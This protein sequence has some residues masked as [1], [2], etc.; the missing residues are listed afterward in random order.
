MNKDGLAVVILHYGRPELAARIHRQLLRSDPDWSGDIFVLDNAAPE[1]YAGAWRRCST[2]LHWAGALEYC[3]G[4]FSAQGYSH[5]WFLNND[6]Y[7]FA[8]KDIIAQAWIRYKFACRKWGRVGVYSPAAHRNPY[9]PQMVC[10]PEAEFSLVRYVD[11]IAPLVDMDFWKQIGGIDFAGNPYGYGV[12][13]WCTSRAPELGWVV[14]VDHRI[15]LRHV[16]HSTSARIDGYLGTASA[17]EDEY[18]KTRMG[19]DYRDRIKAMAKD[20]QLVGANDL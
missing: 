18:L 1:A 12:D 8:H 15:V 6:I 14:V 9:H 17:A 4:E 16:Y 5:L 7:F 10:R 2:N 20:C 13:I 3:L 11:G 19:S